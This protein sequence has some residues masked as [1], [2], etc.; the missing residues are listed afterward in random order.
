MNPLRLWAT[1]FCAALLIPALPGCDSADTSGDDPLNPA[2]T[3][4]IALFPVE[5]D[6]D[7]GYM[8]PT[9]RLVIQPEYSEA[10]SFS[11]G[12][13]PASRWISGRGTVWFYLRQN[14]SVAFEIVAHDA[15]PF[16]DGLARVNADGRWGFIDTTG[17]YVVNPFM[18]SA[19]DF[20]EGR[21]RV[22]TTGYR[23]SFMDTS[24]AVVIETEFD[25]IEDFADGLALYEE[26]GRWGYLDPAGAVAIIPQFDEAR[27]F[28][29]GR[30]A[31]K[32][33]ESWGYIATDGQFV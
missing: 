1:V 9:G 6:G 5:R 23:W 22:K 25:E 17:T 21:A 15:Y 27:S 3:A 24:G 12:L 31:V 2:G 8:D 13:A 16:H 28:S 7:W 20:S 14:G 18:N 33:G 32:V 30:A 26:D 11:E 4:N 19:R 29:D 10:F